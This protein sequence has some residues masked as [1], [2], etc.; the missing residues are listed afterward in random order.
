M[1]P[2]VGHLGDKLCRAMEF[3]LG[4]QA[5]E[6]GVIIKNGHDLTMFA[7]RRAQEKK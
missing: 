5:H 6:A 3:R 4:R 1:V 2:V 7:L